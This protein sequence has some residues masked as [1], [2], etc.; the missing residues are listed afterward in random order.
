M[1]MMCRPIYLSIYLYTK[2]DFVAPLKSVIGRGTRTAV[3]VLEIY[4]D[5]S[6][7]RTTDDVYGS[8]NAEG[9]C[10]HTVS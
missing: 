2:S 4:D 7:Q 9:P 10:E 6:W 5:G 1:F 3:N 8:A